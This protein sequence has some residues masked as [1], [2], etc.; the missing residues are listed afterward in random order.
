VRSLYRFAPVPAE[1]FYFRIPLEVALKRILSGRPSLKWYE[2]GLDLGLHID[3]VESYRRFQAMIMEQYEQITPEFGLT[4]MD[5]TK[6]VEVQ[7]RLLRKTVAP[8][9]KGLY[10]RARPYAQV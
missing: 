10:R 7:Q 8:H 4:V 5:A 9:L 1:A 6:A 3:P 2:A